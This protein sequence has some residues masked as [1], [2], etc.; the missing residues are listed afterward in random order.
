LTTKTRRK[1]VT[2]SWSSVRFPLPP[3]K[4]RTAGFPQYGFKLRV[5][6]SPAAFPFSLLRASPQQT[7]H[8]FFLIPEDF[9]ARRQYPQASMPTVT[10]QAQRPF[11]HPTYYHRR[12]RYG[13]ILK[14]ERFELYALSIS[15]QN[16]EVR[17][18]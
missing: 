1:F 18:S 15:H 11:T 3:L 6:P 16:D 17:L 10:T 14:A 9:I 13:A 8:S 5:C 2:P 12:H 7:Q 4:F